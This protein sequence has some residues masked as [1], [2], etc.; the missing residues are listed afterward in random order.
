MSRFR[1]K[2]IVTLK[3]LKK[4]IGKYQGQ[5][6]IKNGDT[7]KYNN[8]NVKID[9][10]ISEYKK[11]IKPSEMNIESQQKSDHPDNKF[12]YTIDIK[13]TVIDKNKITQKLLIVCYNKYA[14]TIFRGL[15]YKLQARAISVT[16]SYSCKLC[17]D[18]S[19]IL[20]D[21]LN[22]PPGVNNKEIEITY[23]L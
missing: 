19:T 9:D 18:R 13:N 8:I 3:E 12:Y 1:H 5:N 22:I 14:W 23:Y 11:D 15:Y 4:F 17:A 2:S 21:D 20:I 16:S 10:K 6:D 7:Q